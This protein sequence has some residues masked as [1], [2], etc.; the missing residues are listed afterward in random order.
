MGTKVGFFVNHQIELLKKYKPKGVIKLGLKVNPLWDGSK[1]PNIEL[2]SLAGGIAICS[3]SLD[4]IEKLKYDID[5]IS[6]GLF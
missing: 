6:I 4:D 1:H 5:V 3:C 2:H